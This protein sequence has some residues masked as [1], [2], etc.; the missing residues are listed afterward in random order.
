MFFILGGYLEMRA[1]GPVILPESHG[2]VMMPGVGVVAAGFL[3]Q[4]ANI[5]APAA[6]DKLKRIKR[7]T[8]TS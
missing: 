1:S 4:E 5:K 8:K 3:A 2:K 6:R 7:F